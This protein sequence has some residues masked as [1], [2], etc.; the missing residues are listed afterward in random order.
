MKNK[1]IFRGFRYFWAG[2]KAAGKEIWVSLEVLLVLTSM[3]AIL[4]YFVEHN[5]QPENYSNIWDSFVWSFMGY[6]GNPGKFAPADPITLSGRFLWIM[7]SLI[8][9]AI[10]AIPAGLVAK[11]FGE[12]SAKDAKEKKDAVNA[13]R[14]IASIHTHCSTL[15]KVRFWPKKVYRFSEL[16]VN[17]G[18]NESDI[19]SAVNS[20]DKLRLRDLGVCLTNTKGVKPEMLAVEY[21]Y[22]N[23]G[24]GYSTNREEGRQLSKVTIVCPIAAS[25]A[26]LGYYG[27]HLARIGHFNV[28]INEQLSSNA[29]AKEN[30]CVVTS[31]LKEQYEDKENYPKLCEYV[32]DIKEL[33]KDDDNLAVVIRVMESPNEEH[34]HQKMKMVV[35]VGEK[36]EDS[37]L[38]DATNCD[39]QKLE[40]FYKDLHDT[41]LAEHNIETTIDYDTLPKGSL[42][43]YIH[44]FNSKPNVIEI[45]IAHDYRVFST[46][47]KA[48]LYSLITLA[49]LIHKH[50]DD[51]NTQFSDPA[52]WEKANIIEHR[53]PLIPNHANE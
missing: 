38:L 51:G 9:L 44:A 30:R 13:E 39:V 42:Q 6:L 8:K 46:G 32:D 4:L 11:G 43:N 16:K 49:S 24:Y 12:A 48:P 45:R 47:V 21:V 40:A 15:K 33:T 17:L 10:F 2:I 26:A 23:N 34:K 1:D 3:L 41:M 18:L 20:S 25:Q 5:A 50:F 7:I 53:V 14:I 35:N 22:G 31:I 36:K 27:Y 19:V 37:S 29:D 28:V 52:T